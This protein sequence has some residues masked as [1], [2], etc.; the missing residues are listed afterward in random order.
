M[1]E[2][3]K[4]KIVSVSEALRLDS[5]YYAIRGII[6]SV[7]EVYH[8]VKSSSGKCYKC[9]AMNEGRTFEP[10]INYSDF[11]FKAKTNCINCKED[12]YLKPLNIPAITI[13]IRN[14]DSANDLE[15]IK[16]VLFD[17]NTNGVVAGE[18]VFAVGDIVVT[19][20]K[21]KGFSTIYAKKVKYEGREEVKLSLDDALEIEK[22]AERKDNK[23]ELVGE[24]VSMVAPSVIGH[25]DKKEGL[26][27]SSVMT[28]EDK[29]RRKTR[30]H[31]LFI[32]P[33][34]G[35]KTELLHGAADLVPGSTV[36]SGQGSTGLS[37]TAM[38]VKEDD[39]TALKIGPIP[40]ARGKICC[41]N[42]INKQNPADQDKLMDFMQEGQS[43]INKY[44][45]SAPIR[46][47]T[48]I[49]ASAN[50][51]RGDFT[52]LENGKID[53]NEVTIIS[54][55]RDRFDLTFVF[56]Q[57][58]QHNKL[59]EYADSKG[60]LLNQEEIPVCSPFL[61]RYIMHAK[62]INPALSEI[63]M[64][65][66]NRCY[67]DLAYDN[68]VSPRKLETLYNLAKARAKLKLKDI[69]D[70]EDAKETV[71]YFSRV[72]NEYYQSTVIAT[73]PRDVCVSIIEQILEQNSKSALTTGPINFTDLII[74]ACEKDQQVKL[75]IGPDDHYHNLSMS[76]N[77][78]LRPIAQLL[79]ENKHVKRTKTK[80]LM[81]QWIPSAAAV[82]N[83]EP[84]PSTT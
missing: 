46:G 2:K 4:V 11:R 44:G 80:P 51:V 34:G 43:N 45:H 42:E 36:Q 81:F 37:L 25:Y 78:K 38:V 10:P 13:E 16:V 79:Q 55:L 54:A 33:P 61:V 63:A 70:A 48:T 39:T 18:Q 27:L 31:I 74:M 58:H 30:V 72:V 22:F 12:V 67:A 57:E 49:I 5:G 69:V 40:R 14:P 19:E 77:H 1:K 76:N 50:P 20:N 52:I 26:L 23:R 17:K 66:L 6:T 32:G 47:P 29:P 24:L 64:S 60:R 8:M 84:S 62:K 28:P 9:G 73:D 83:E 15:G 41:I 82:P 68:K 56:Q 7:T 35:A 75:Y 53:I 21:G 3:T 59:L 71:N 65:I